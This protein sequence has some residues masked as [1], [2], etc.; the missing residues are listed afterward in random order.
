MTLNFENR[1]AWDKNVADFKTHYANEDN[2]IK[3]I[4][5]RFLSP[6]SLIVSDR[7]LYVIQLVRRDFPEKDMVSIFCKSLPPHPECPEN[8]KDVRAHMYIS[9]FVFKPLVGPDS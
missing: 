9:A 7:F 6:A 8:P 2:T 5:H 1:M 4:S 3:R